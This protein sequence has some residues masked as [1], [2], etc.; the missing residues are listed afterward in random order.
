[1]TQTRQ[2]LRSPPSHAAAAAVS[3]AR[4]ASAAAPTRP[5]S[6][7]TRACVP[8]A[9]R[10]PASSGQGS[11]VPTSG[12]S[13]GRF[14][15]AARK[16]GSAVGTGAANVILLFALMGAGQSHESSRTPNEP[17]HTGPAVAHLAAYT[18]PDLW[19]AVRREHVGVVGGTDGSPM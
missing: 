6:T 2:C 3:T 13:Q 16:V 7:W 8:R 11:I 9:S 12:S 1:M 10:T 17:S 5:R 4:R 18:Q 15:R 19:P 14:R